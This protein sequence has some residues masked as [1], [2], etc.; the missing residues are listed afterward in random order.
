MKYLDTRN[1]ERTQ[2]VEP[3]DTPMKLEVL[4]YMKS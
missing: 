3:V 4:A 2:S 1:H